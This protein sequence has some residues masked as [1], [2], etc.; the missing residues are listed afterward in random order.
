MHDSLAFDRT[1]ISRPDKFNA[2]FFKNIATAEGTKNKNLP[3]CPV[4]GAKDGWA[5]LQ[6]V[7]RNFKFPKSMINAPIFNI[8]SLSVGVF[9]KTKTT[10]VHLLDM[11][12]LPGTLSTQIVADPMGALFAAWSGLNPVYY[13]TACLKTIKANEMTRQM[14]YTTSFTLLA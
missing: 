12:Q 1:Q 4:R 9:P 7:L 10:A 5:C 6:A 3:K 14:L 2:S 11:L 8:N 13:A